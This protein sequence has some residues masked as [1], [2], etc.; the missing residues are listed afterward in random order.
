MAP[1]F[2]RRWSDGR[3][4]NLL[5]A[6][7]RVYWSK[8]FGVEEEDLFVAVDQVGTLAEDVRQY[9]NRQLTHHWVVDGGRE[10]RRRKSPS[11]RFFQ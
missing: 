11:R 7:D 3:R 5:D 9:L 4:I 6:A 2:R 1:P 8:F 10:E